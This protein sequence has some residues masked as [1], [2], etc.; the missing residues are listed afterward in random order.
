MLADDW[1]GR[2]TVDLDEQT[3]RL[4]LQV[5]GRSVFGLDLGERATG[6]GRRSSSC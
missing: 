2:S 3:R 4:T 6:W 5:I 1:I